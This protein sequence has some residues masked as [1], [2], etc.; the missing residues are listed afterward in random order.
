MDSGGEIVPG[1]SWIC[2][3]KRRNTLKS[4]RKRQGKDVCAWKQWDKCQVETK[5]N[6]RNWEAASLKTGPRETG[7]F[8]KTMLWKMWDWMK[9][10]S[11]AARTMQRMTHKAPM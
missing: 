6:S 10:G 1:G 2:R 11:V 4:K 9:A 8:R 3:N 5:D 7:V